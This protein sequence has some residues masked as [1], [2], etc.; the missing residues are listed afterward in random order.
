MSEGQFQIGEKKVMKAKSST[1]LLSI[2]VLVLSLLGG[3]TYGFCTHIDMACFEWGPDFD[4]R[5][6]C[7]AGIL[8]GSIQAEFANRDILVPGLHCGNL[9][10][11]VNGQCTFLLSS[12]SCGGETA[13]AGCDL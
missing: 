8:D 1:V 6:T 4:F 13:T 12:S 9:Y 11:V 2:L 7:C 10:Q 3:V 5:E